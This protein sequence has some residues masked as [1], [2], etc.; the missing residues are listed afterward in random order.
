MVWNKTPEIVC[1]Q[2]IEEVK[3]PLTTLSE[4][5]AR[6]K[7]SVDTVGKIVRKYLT[8]EERKTRHSVQLSLS[9]TGK[10][11][12]MY[13]KSREAHPR[14]NKGITRVAGYITVPAPLWWTGPIVKAPRI[15][16]HHLVWAEANGATEI[17][18]GFC[19]H[20]LD[21]NKDNN[22]ASNL[23]LLSLSAHMKLHAELRKVQRL[24]REGVGV[25]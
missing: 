14:F 23:I 11:N 24:S 1:M 16:Q 25:K 15:Y 13:G 19:V 9:Q 20:H 4:L 5:S 3:N 18:T 22:V 8:K 21:E 6:Y 7:L 12:S 17:P 10:R 2:I